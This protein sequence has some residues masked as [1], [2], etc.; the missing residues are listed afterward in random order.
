MEYL[1]IN[2]MDHGI[3]YKKIIFGSMIFYIP[4]LTFN[5]MIYNSLDNIDKTLN[6]PDNLDYIHK[7]KIII[8]G[9]CKDIINCSNL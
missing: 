2:N 7:I 5:I 9:V 1:N 6:T 8:D 4:L 3:N